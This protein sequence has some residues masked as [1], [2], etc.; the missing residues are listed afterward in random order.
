MANTTNTDAPEPHA[1]V[2]R[3]RAR[4]L[5]WRVASLALG[6]CVGLILAE[7]GVWLFCPPQSVTF[8]DPEQQSFFDEKLP[9]SLDVYT[10]SGPRM[11]ANSQ[12]TIRRHGLNQRTIS[13]RTNEHGFRGPPLG[14][15]QPGE[16][17]VLIL[18]DS[19]TFAD[20]VQEDE[21]FVH[22]VSTRLARELSKPVRV[23]NGG[24]PGSDLLTQH[25]ILLESCRTIR[26][27]LV[28]VASYLNDASETEYVRPLTGVWSRSALVVKVHELLNL[29]AIESR[30]AEQ[31]PGRPPPPP[32]ASSPSR[33]GPWLR[34]H[35][36]FLR[37]RDSM[38]RDW[39]YAWDPRCWEE[40][41]SVYKPLRDYTESQKIPLAVVLLPVAQQV[42][43]EW[44]DDTPQRH[45][46]SLMSELDIPHHDLLPDLRDAAQEQ[47]SL[48]YD[49]CHLTPE[50]N[51]L[52]GDRIARFLLSSPS[53]LD[54]GAGGHQ[55]QP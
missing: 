11:R 49:H 13:L 44:E 10:P 12:L 37:I 45:F 2:S 51:A 23:V 21:T 8:A 17:R 26:P 22:H 53:V 9:R 31:F 35:A 28:V 55:S 43:A 27:D 7:V 30:R 36:T 48:Y 19:I 46:R 41:R 32:A 1:R 42:Y 38:S 5:A 4:R 50:G 6:S 52:V 18:G 14:P 29:R 25:Y 24:R 3:S 40:L 33:G 54:R 16:T 39:G 34:D 20:Y 47:R 15:K